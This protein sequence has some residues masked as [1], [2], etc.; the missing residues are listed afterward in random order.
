MPVRCATCNS[1]FSSVG[2][3]ADHVSDTYHGIQGE[4]S[5][6]GLKPPTSDGPREM[7]L[8]LDG[9]EGFAHRKYYDKKGDIITM[10]DSIYFSTVCLLAGA[11][12]CFDL[13]CG[14]KFSNN[15]QLNKH[16]LESGH[17]KA[18]YYQSNTNRFGIVF[19]NKHRYDSKKIN[20]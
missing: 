5:L 7:E 18:Q 14:E 20:N 11:K 13:K 2:Q 1:Q 8:Y 19:K 6:E 10:P 16:V 17:S 12:R 15:Y 9:V 4:L 3:V